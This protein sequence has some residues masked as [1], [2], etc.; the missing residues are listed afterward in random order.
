MP[1]AVVTSVG[2][3]LKGYLAVAVADQLFQLGGGV[4]DAQLVYPAALALSALAAIVGHNYSLFLGFTGGAGSSPNVGA[5]LW[6]DPLT[7]GIVLPVAI[8]FLF[9]VRIASLAS[10]AISAIILVGVSYRVYEGALPI[11]TLVYAIG[12]AL[13]VVWAL[14]PNIARLLSGTERRVEFGRRRIRNQEP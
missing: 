11:E 13:L 1:A 3:I 4:P 9:G 5:V 8:V 7:F 2:D 6:F 10:I 12:Q 14:R